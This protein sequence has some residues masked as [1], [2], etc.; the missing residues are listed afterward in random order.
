MA[1][2]V[3]VVVVSYLH[4]NILDFCLAHLS[5]QTHSNIDIAVWDNC[6]NSSMLESKYPNVSFTF[7]E[8]NVLWS[9]GVNRCIEKNIK[10]RH[11][12][13]LIMN[14]DIM[15]PSVAV[16]R[17][18]NNFALAEDNPGIIAPAGSGIGGLQD[19]VSNKQIPLHSDWSL[20]L[21]DKIKNFDLIRSN[22]AIGAI[23]MIDRNLYDLI[24]GLD[25]GMPL[26]A[27]DFDYCIRAREAGFSIWVAYNIYVNHICHVT[28]DSDAWNEFGGLSWKRFNEKY[29]G[30]F[31][32]EQEAIGALWG[33]VY[34]PNYPLGSG[35][36]VDEKINRG[37][38]YVSR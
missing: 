36:S 31:A 4:T 1:D 22:Y 37:I 6:G 2:D 32:S 26:G 20:D 3:L 8:E 19:Y 5:N 23:Q 15:L 24:G 14:H 27:D 18:V 13:I 17:L 10:D 16:E 33:G 38:L 25:E 7:S 35:L 12:F 11:K 29:D 30:Y 28:G 9:P 21:Q 34:D